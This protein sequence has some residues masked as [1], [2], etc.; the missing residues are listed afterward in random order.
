LTAYDLAT[1]KDQT[2]CINILRQHGGAKSAVNCRTGSKMRHEARL[3]VQ[4]AHDAA[5]R[6]AQYWITD[7]LQLQQQADELVTATVNNATSSL[8]A[9]RGAHDKHKQQRRATKVRVKYVISM[10]CLL[11]RA[12]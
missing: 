6:E 5:A 3:V 10:P 11:C 4:Q 2:E 12:L 9:T 7:E 8:T 1:A